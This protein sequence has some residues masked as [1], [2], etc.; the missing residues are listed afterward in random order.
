M[1]TV[2]DFVTGKHL[3]QPAFDFL[4]G[5]LAFL[6]KFKSDVIKDV[7]LV[8]MPD[9][10]AAAEVLTERNL[11]AFSS[12]FFSLWGAKDNLCFFSSY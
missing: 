11:S 4:H 10:F 2:S 3:R 5:E 6:G 7:N 12:Y 9:S 8:E 1:D